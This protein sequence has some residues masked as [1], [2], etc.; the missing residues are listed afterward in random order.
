MELKNY[1]CS[2][3]GHQ[4]LDAVKYCQECKLYLCNECEK[5][6][7]GF[8]KN[9]HMFPLDEDID[10]PKYC[11]EK[12]HQNELNYFCK[13]HNVLCCTNCIAKIKTRENGKHHDCNVCDINDICEEKRKNLS[14]NIKTLENLSN[15]IQS[16][17]NDLKK[18]WKKLIKTKKK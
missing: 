3:E 13:D 2:F 10:F 16:L 7:F 15:V 12:N 4:N 17:I 8:F 5:V 1:K 18:I 14:N 6:H 11:K 9:R